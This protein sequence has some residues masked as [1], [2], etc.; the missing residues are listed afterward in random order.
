MLESS[1]LIK[2]DY[3]Y[4]II[5]INPPENYNINIILINPPENYDYIKLEG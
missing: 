2:N 5:L 4:I 1:K 3:I